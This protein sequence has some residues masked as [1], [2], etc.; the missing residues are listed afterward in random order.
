MTHF[1]QFDLPHDIRPLIEQMQ[2]APHGLDTGYIFMDPTSPESGALARFR[3]VRSELAS[4]AENAFSHYPATPRTPLTTISTQSEQA[5]FEQVYRQKLGLVIGESHIQRS[6]KQLL[7]EHMELLKKQGV[8]TLYI[9]HLLTDLHQEALDIYH[10][11]SKMPKAL[12]NYLELLDSDRMPMYGGDYTYTNIVKTAHK[13]GIRV[14]ALDCSA[15]YHVK[16]LTGKVGR[17][18]LFSYFANEVI[19]ADQL[20]KGAHKWVAFVGT[21]HTDMHKGVPG[22]V[23]LQ[24]AISLHVY[25]T[26]PQRAKRLR[27]GGWGHVTDTRSIVALRSDFSIDVGN[28]KAPATRTPTL[29]DRTRLTEPG[30]FFIE[31][32][33]EFDVNLVHRSRSGQ[34]VTTPFQINGKGQYFIEYWSALKNQRF[35]DLSALIET[36]KADPP[37]GAGLRQIT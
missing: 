7:N 2:A 36:L 3:S 13:F 25:D 4:T 1:A 12:K 30:Q 28:L 15:S 18:E 24:D 16:G 35:Y 31:Y 8:K 27:G 9:E 6:A 29:P 22:L 5:F 10:R 37:Q 33:S 34:I 21:A 14:R 19:K 32:P 23:E 11:T 26:T 17:L 20:A